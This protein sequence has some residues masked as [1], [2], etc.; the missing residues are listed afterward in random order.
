MRCF[1]SPLSLTIAF[2]SFHIVC[3]VLTTLCQVHENAKFGPKI[4]CVDK[5]LGLWFKLILIRFLRA[6]IY[7]THTTNT[8]WSS[9]NG[10]ASDQMHYILQR[11]YTIHLYLFLLLLLGTATLLP[12]LDS[13]KVMNLVCRLPLNNKEW[14]LVFYCIVNDTR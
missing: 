8:L 12:R 9:R 13:N 10:M 2:L 4:L 11:L 14:P 3:S 5:A 1:F 7:T 6:A